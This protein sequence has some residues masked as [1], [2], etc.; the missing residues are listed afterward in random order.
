MTRTLL[1]LA[2]A[3]ASAAAP[4][5]AARAPAPAGEPFA[6]A[7]PA[8]DLDLASPAG[9]AAFDARVEALAE[10]SCAPRRFPAAYEPES[11]ERCRADFRAAAHAAADRRSR[12]RGAPAG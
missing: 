11:L 12:A 7:V 10:R 2:A 6:V 4:A 5:A 1:L 8:S 3:A 9:R